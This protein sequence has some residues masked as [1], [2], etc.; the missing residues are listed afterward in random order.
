MHTLRAVTSV[1]SRRGGYRGMRWRDARDLAPEHRPGDGGNGLSSRLS[2][3]L[4]GAGW[5]CHPTPRRS[6][7]EVGTG[8]KS[9]GNRWPSH[10]KVEAVGVHHLVPRGNEVGHELRFRVGGA[11]DFGEGAQF[12]VGS[13]PCDPA[14]TLL[15]LFGGEW[16]SVKG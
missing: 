6:I 8:S 13:G 7:S 14:P 3:V 12:R 11:I 5:R 4:R 15:G 10:P 9:V 2:K 16:R 1:E